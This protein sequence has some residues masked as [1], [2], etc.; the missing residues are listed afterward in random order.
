MAFRQFFRSPHGN[1][2]AV[3][4][5]DPVRYD[6]PVLRRPSGVDGVQVPDLFPIS[7]GH[8]LFNACWRRYAFRENQIRYHAV[9]TASGRNSDPDAFHSYTGRVYSCPPCSRDRICGFAHD[10]GR[11]VFFREERGR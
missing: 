7:T 2:Q 9:Q 5:A 11:T 3:G 6:R 1:Q 10:P 8:I 4:C